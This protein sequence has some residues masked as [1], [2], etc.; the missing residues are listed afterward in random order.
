MSNERP[1]EPPPFNALPDIATQAR[2]AKAVVPVQPAVASGGDQAVAASAAKVAAALATQN[3][4][5]SE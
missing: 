1:Y 5:R 2:P 3:I 4:K